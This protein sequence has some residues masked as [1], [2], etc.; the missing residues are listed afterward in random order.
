MQRL[1]KDRSGGTFPVHLVAITGDTTVKC[2]SG[3]CFRRVEMEVVVR[4]GNLFCYLTVHRCNT[5]QREKPAAK[6]SDQAGHAI[7]ITANDALVRSVNNQEVGAGE[8]AKCPANILLGR[9]DHTETPLYGFMPAE[10]PGALSGPAFARQIMG[11]KGRFFHAAIHLIPVAPG[12]LGK[13]PR[14]FTQTVAD[15]SGR[16]HAKVLDQIADGA[17]RGYLTK[18]NGSMIGINQ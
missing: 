5:L 1:A 9:S 10:A 16:V 12:T 14:R 4:Y 18:N 7:R 17:S 8:C 11:E 15:D 13:E 2:N 6:C 3:R